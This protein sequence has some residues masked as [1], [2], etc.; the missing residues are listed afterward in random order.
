MKIDWKRKLTSRKF[1]VAVIMI[2]AGVLILFGANGQAVEL[3]VG[4]ALVAL[5]GL[6]Y[7]VAEAKVDIANAKETAITV[8]DA[9]GSIVDAVNKV[10]GKNE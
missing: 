8:I 1:I 4:G 6:G 5:G 3:I 10:G 9:A 2:L 7:N